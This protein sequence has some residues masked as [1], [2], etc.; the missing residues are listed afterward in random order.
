MG[1]EWIHGEGHWVERQGAPISKMEP[2]AEVRH[3]IKWIWNI[4]RRVGE[5]KR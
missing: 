3:T 1:D 4:G 5:I 2:A